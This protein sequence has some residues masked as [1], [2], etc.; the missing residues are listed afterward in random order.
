MGDDGKVTVQFGD[1]KAGARLP[2]GSENVVAAYRIGIGLQGNVSAG[3]LTTLL[4]RPLGLR[5]AINPLPA[6]GGADSETRDRARRNAPQSVRTLDRIVSLMDYEDFARTF[7]GIG[8]AQAIWLWNGEAR[9]VHLTVAGDAGEVLGFSS[10]VM[11]NLAEALKTYRDPLV[12]VRTDSYEPVTFKVKAGVMVDEGYD[13]GKVWAGVRDAL[14]QGFSFEARGFGQPVTRSEV[15]AV[16]QR[17]PGVKAVDLNALFSDPQAPD[18]NPVRLPAETAR[19]NVQDKEIELAQILTLDEAAS[20][21]ES[22][23]MAA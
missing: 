20:A 11:T 3:Q 15:L 12:Q 16:I 9:I 2:S 13:P 5:E 19:W 10:K 4:T 21:I 22:S 23:E 1:G 7:S 18:L 17:V 6:E 14:R 8:K